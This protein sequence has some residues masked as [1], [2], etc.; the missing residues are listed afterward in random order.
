M[1]STTNIL[2]LRYPLSCASISIHCSVVDFVMS[3]HHSDRVCDQNIFNS[4]LIL[5]TDIMQHC[6]IVTIQEA[7][8]NVRTFVDGPAVSLSSGN[9]KLA[10][11]TAS[12]WY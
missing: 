7:D 10:A 4:P 9:C 5:V 6:L 8:D 12:L 2:L 11:K 3:F 1:R